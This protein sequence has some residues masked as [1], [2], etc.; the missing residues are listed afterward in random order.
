MAETVNRETDV[1]TN[2]SKA[3]LVLGLGL[4]AVAAQFIAGAVNG[5]G[6]EYGW[7]WFVGAAIGLAA[8]VLGLKST[9]GK[10]KGKAL[11][12]TILGGI[13]VLIFLAFAVGIME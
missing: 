8:V 6:D 1:L 4:G 3:N 10:P 2:V 7:M 9:S 11:I 12:G 13:I 5:D